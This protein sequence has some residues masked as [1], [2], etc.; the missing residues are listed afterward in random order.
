MSAEFDAT[1]E[2]FVALFGDNDFAREAAAR[3]VQLCL[4]HAREM[5]AERDL[6]ERRCR[7]EWEDLPSPTPGYARRC[8]YI[9]EL[10]RWEYQV[11]CATDGREATFSVSDEISFDSIGE[12]RRR[13]QALIADVMT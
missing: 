7:G 1:V 10:C 8:R 11:V 3:S 12:L 2:A 5:A 6:R 9:K 4:E 13:E